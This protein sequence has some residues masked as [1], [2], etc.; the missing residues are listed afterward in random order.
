MNGQQNSMDKGNNEAIAD[1]MNIFIENEQKKI[2][3]TLQQL[4]DN[5]QLEQLLNQ[6]SSQQYNGTHQRINKEHMSQQMMPMNCNSFFM[7]SINN[8]VTKAIQ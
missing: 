4:S 3:K 1:Q 5:P 6:N 8:S 2:L 7:T